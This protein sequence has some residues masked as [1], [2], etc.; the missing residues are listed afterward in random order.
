MTTDWED[1]RV[2]TKPMAMTPDTL[3]P[4]PSASPIT[5]EDKAA[6]LARRK[7]ERKQVGLFI[8]FLCESWDSFLSLPSQRIAMLK[9][10]KKNAAKGS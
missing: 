2:E 1:D 9:E 3:S 10:Q 8:G 5:K 4:V 7:E 6:E